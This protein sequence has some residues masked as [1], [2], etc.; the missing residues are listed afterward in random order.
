[1]EGEEVPADPGR[2]CWICLSGTPAVSDPD[3]PSYNL[4]WVE[5]CRCKGSLKVR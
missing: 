1:M 2:V 5:P 3:N 4:E